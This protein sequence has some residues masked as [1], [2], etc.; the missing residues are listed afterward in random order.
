[1]SKRTSFDGMTADYVSAER[2][3][4]GIAVEIADLG[5]SSLGFVIKPSLAKELVFHLQAMLA[6]TRTASAQARPKS[7]T[8]W[9]A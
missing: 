4:D 1:M 7:A 5:D 9:L 8:G 3:E 2:L 6:I